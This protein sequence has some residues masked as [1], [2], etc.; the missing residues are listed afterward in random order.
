MTSWK[1]GDRIVHP[2]FGT[3][4]VLEWNDQH[5][6]VHFDDR[7]RR[8]FASSMVV[9]NPVA[10]AA[11]SSAAPKAAA[12]SPSPQGSTERRADGP[13]VVANAP[14]TIEQLMD[15]ARTKVSS[16]ASFNEFVS[17][18]RRVLPRPNR[19]SVGLLSGMTVPE[20][21][22]WLL[23]ANVERQLTDA[24]LLAVVRLEFP[25]V[26]GP[27]FTGDIETGLK[28]MALIR[29]QYNRQAHRGPGPADGDRLDSVSYGRF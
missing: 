23:D 7:G 13:A 26:A 15:L 25:L 16:A 19:Q 29:T 5:A 1:P 28:Q 6:I 21:Q 12:T 18:C 17:S 24:Q 8:K 14:S 27:L 3:G 2:T 22:T 11:G 4:T 9:L 10:A 20:F